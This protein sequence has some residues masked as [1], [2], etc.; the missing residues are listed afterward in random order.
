M[1]A[2]CAF[3]SSQAEVLKRES[4]E[5]ALKQHI[6]AFSAQSKS[7]SRLQL[8]DRVLLRWRQGKTSKRKLTQPLRV[9]G[10]TVV[11]SFNIKHKDIIG[12]ESDV[13]LWN[14]SKDGL[15]KLGV[16]ARHPNLD[17]FT[18]LSPRRVAPIYAT[19]ASTIVSLLDINVD[20]PSVDNDPEQHGTTFQILEAGTGHGSLTLQLS[21]AIAAANHPP[22]ADVK[23]TP[24]S[25]TV[26]KAGEE[27]DDEVGVAESEAMTTWRSQRRAVVHTV[28]IDPENRKHAEQLIRSYRSGLYW[29]HVNFYAGNVKEWLGSNL[30]TNGR[31]PFL[32][33]VVLD[34]PGLERYISTVV[35]GIKDGG[36]LLVFAPQI[37][38]IATCVQEIVTN[39][40]GLKL[41]KVV[42]LG[43]G[44]S[45]G[46]LWDVRMASLK[47]A[48]SRLSKFAIEES[49]K[50]QGTGHAKDL[51]GEQDSLEPMVGTIPPMV[52]RPIVGEM[53][54]GGGFVALWKRMT[55]SMI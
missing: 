39:N 7:C 22:S 16:S 50:E 6:R 29:P 9:D 49:G 25:K 27:V 35:E 24:S 10:V 13:R 21:R 34:M 28:D 23:P 12:Q 52:C 31:A 38:Q 55:T 43:D 46:R 15:R 32:D 40:L 11:D 8:G 48:R 19:Y 30:E 44:I 37:T 4:F 53:T 5:H 1:L 54:R 14:V 18:S 17:E 33:V 3:R 20:P 51:P 26:Y 45:T 36:Q 47:N 42:E 41:E 2:R